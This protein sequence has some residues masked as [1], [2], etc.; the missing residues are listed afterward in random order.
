M[1]HISTQRRP[2]VQSKCLVGRKLNITVVLYCD[3]NVVI[4]LHRSASGNYHP[5]LLY[6]IFEQRAVFVPFKKGFSHKMSVIMQMCFT[7]YMQ[8]LRG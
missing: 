4:I 8:I 7:L 5:N 2:L 1:L 6:I 3:V